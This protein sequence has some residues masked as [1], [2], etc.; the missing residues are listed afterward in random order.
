M[1]FIIGVAVGFLY[2]AYDSSKEIKLECLREKLVWQ[3]S[4]KKGRPKSHRA[5]NLDSIRKFEKEED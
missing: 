4:L 2:Q 3:D 1:I 5:Y